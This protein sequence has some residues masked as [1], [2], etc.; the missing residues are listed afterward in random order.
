MK[1]HYVGHSTLVVETPKHKILID[2]WTAGSAYCDQWHLF[3][4]PVNVDVTKDADVILVTHGHEDHLHHETLVSLSKKAHVFYPFQ[5]MKG[6]DHYLHELGFSKI[7]EAIT[8]KP[9][10]LSDGT[11]IT[12]MANAL[13]SI[14]VIECD[15]KVM[16]NVN[17]ALPA[18][19]LHIIRKFTRTLSS[20]WPAIDYLFCGYGSAAYFP[21]TVHCE[22]KDDMEIAETREQMFAHNFCTI[23]EDLKPQMVIPFAADYVLLNNSR[24]WINEVKLSKQAIAKYYHQQF[25]R[26]PVRFLEMH[27]G[28]IIA[29]N[30]F[31]A[32][33]PYHAR[34]QHGRLEHLIEEQL[35]ESE[36]RV[37]AVTW[38]TREEED[39]LLGEMKANIQKRMSLFSPDVLSKIRYSVRISDIRNRPFFFVDC[40]DGKEARITRHEEAPAGSI[41][42]LETPAR[43]LRYCF[44]SEWGGDAIIIGYGAEIYIH[45][46]EII[47]QN[48]DIVC[49]R[50]LTRQPVA[51]KQMKRHP[52]RA[53]TYL[54][55]NPL[56][57]GW[58]V[59]QLITG[60][61]NVNK[62]PVNERDIWLSKSKCEI[63]QVCNIP[64]LSSDFAET[65]H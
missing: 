63:C 8:L 34:L 55:T 64:Y 36:Q 2:P 33:S 27:S 58:A 46:K 47:H 25:N 52:V 62:N 39:V 19:H 30:V 14:V 24:K 4:L 38:C 31:Q 45:D 22:G 23:V 43:I 44:A 16:M 21:N 18:N 5:W 48:L 13:D 10:T 57:T 15:G 1:I 9:Y 59:R 6:I 41:L 26:V 60:R 28:D 32:L 35:A 11:K 56:T 20:R 50:L 12:Y 54:A 42:T 29:D 51:S 17:D 65:V 53:F 61:N 7:T 40:S 3:P 37:N 49:V